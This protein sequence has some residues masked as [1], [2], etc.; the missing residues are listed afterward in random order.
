[1]PLVVGVIIMVS[2]ATVLVGVVG[3]LVDRS[4]A[5]QEEESKSRGEKSAGNNA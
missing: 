2:G 1:M 3:W 5:R 4:T